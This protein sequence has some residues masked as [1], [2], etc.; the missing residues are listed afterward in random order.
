MMISLLLTG[1]AVLPWPTNHSLETVD[2]EFAPAPG[3]RIEKS[4]TSSVQMESEELTSTTNGQEVPAQYLPDLQIVI[5]SSLEV[6]VRDTYQK[7]ED[8]KPLS[9]RRHYATLIGE[10]DF[11][12][13]MPPAP[14]QFKDFESE[15]SLQ[16]EQVQFNWNAETESYDLELIDKEQTDEDLDVLE[17]DMDL[18]GFL[19]KE[20][21]SAGDS[22]DI[23][24]AAMSKLF[25]P[26][27]D[28]KLDSMDD[29]GEDYENIATTSKLRATLK[30][31]QHV[32]GMQQAVI[33]IEGDYTDKSQRATTLEDIPITDGT[34]METMTTNFQIEGE[35]V[36]N[37]S[38]GHAHALELSSTFD[39]VTDT[40]RDPDQPGVSFTAR[41]TFS[42][43][44]NFEANFTTLTD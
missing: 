25:Q 35:L 37:L 5:E 6:Q 14:E 42:G 20:S 36:W 4:F 39:L 17:A 41:V 34:A 40:V 29:G 7:V 12:M 9:F 2:I 18:L 43:E 13:S 3:T 30:R 38:A 33:E 23:D 19:P 22:W 31:V 26:G 27:G 24:T 11:E 15:H 44:Q 8:G 1:L 28:L 32:D 10:G 16:D 21:V